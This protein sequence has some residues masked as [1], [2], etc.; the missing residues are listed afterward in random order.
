VAAEPEATAELARVCAYLPL[1]LRIAAANLTDHPHRS[2]GRHVTE[3][4]AGD[5]LAALEVEGDEQ[6]AVRIAFGLSYS[7]LPASSR[8]LFRLLGLVPGPDVTPDAAAALAGTT[9]QQAA[10]VLD[11]LAGTHLITQHG[12]GRF[13]FHDLLR[14]YAAERAQGEDS[15]QERDAAAGRLFDWYLYTVDNAARLLYPEKLRL[16]LPAAG[17][18]PAAT[19]FGDHT[20]A[21]AWLDAERPNLL[22]AIRHAG[23][24]GPRPAA[25]LLADALR[26]YFWLRMSTVEWLAAAHAGLA[27][28]EADDELRAQAVAQLSLAD[29]Y[30]HQS[31]YQQAV[32]HFT[33]ALTL[34]GQTGWLAGQ[35]TVLCNL[36]LVYWQS[37]RLPEA[38]DH[39]SQALVIARQTGQIASQAVVLG[40][41]GIVCSESGR[42]RAAADHLT[43]ALALDKKLESRYGLAIAL[44][45][46]G[47]TFQMLGQL[48]HALDHLTQALALQRE[49]GNRSAEADTLRILAAVHRDAGDH[50]QAVEFA[51]S[52]L[53]LARDTGDRRVEADALNSVAA[54]HHRLGRHREAIEGHQRALDLAREL[55]TRYPE[56]VA[57][58]GLA[59]SERTEQPEQ[60]LAHAHQAAALA[61][62]TG[63]RMLEGQAATTLAD[64]Q[65][66]LG[67]AGEAVEQ[68]EQA[69]A[70]HRETGHRVGQVRALVVLGDALRHT[71]GTPAALPVW[72]QALTLAGDIGAAEAGHIRTLIDA[73]A[74]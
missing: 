27:A 31:R 35:A 29:A 24:A 58:I 70:I 34:S 36:G 5:R 3:L 69:L 57:L 25:W 52:A 53:A 65:L 22:A 28:A 66:T 45:N 1:A 18:R 39:L 64:I 13:A 12:P 48:D 41:L 42:L 43:Q 11:R 20:E 40:N 49:I 38:A 46:L 60:A 2:I 4:L 67:A 63:Y 23:A 47:E 30:L 7:T 54:T 62:R 72:R 10:Q 26:G 68:A 59:A 56:V 15:E 71:Q 21:L 6:A 16:P 14:L 8:R 37:G 51:G 33:R 55:E 44:T 73:H 9:S 32:E 50:A 17:S 19:E 74:V 61:C